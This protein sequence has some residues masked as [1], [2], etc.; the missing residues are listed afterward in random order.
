MNLPD[1]YHQLHFIINQNCFSFSFGL[2]LYQP[3]LFIMF[4]FIQ[5]TLIFVK[6]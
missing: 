3:L 2:N 6:Q 4:L 5:L 1:K